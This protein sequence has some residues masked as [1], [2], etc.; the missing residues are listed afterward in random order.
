MVN[1]FVLI[2]EQYFSYLFNSDD[3]CPLKLCKT[4]VPLKPDGVWVNLAETHQI[5][6]SA[7]GSTTN[8]WEEIG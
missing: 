8:G 1:S 4:K 5:N 6:V 3:P 2:D 7:D